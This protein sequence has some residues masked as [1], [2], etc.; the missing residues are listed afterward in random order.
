MAVGKTLIGLCTKH[1]PII[2]FLLLSASCGHNQKV[3]S[4]KVT[5]IWK[6]DRAV[7]ISILQPFPSITEQDSVR[8][9]LS[10]R[11][12]DSIM[13]PAI[14]GEYKIKGDE[15]IF[16]PLIAFTHGL[17][18][19]MFLKNKRIAEIKIPEIDSA[20]APA[21]LA[22]YPTQDTLPYNL[23]KVYLHF[24]KPMREGQSLKYITVLKNNKDTV[25]DVF[26]ELQPEL[27]NAEGTT[28]TLWLDPGRIKRDLQPNKLLGVPLQQ[29]EHYVLLFSD[30]W[31]DIHGARLTKA[32]SKN[33]IVT[34]RDGLSP[35]P[36]KWKIHT[37]QA[38]TV[39]P[40][41]IDFTEPLDKMLINDALN[42]VDEKGAVITGRLQTTDEER[43][44]LFKP[45]EPWIAGRYFIEI[46]T[47]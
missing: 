24:S 41:E 17:H 29:G 45:N 33:F 31:K 2:F 34:I 44:C 23:L 39:D 26:L 19:E 46:E 25:P 38:G 9:F 28:L 6:D 15:I 16:E 32:Y 13:Q 11:L 5:I 18:Y 37:P 27:W 12:T 43:K 22:V 36:Y 7:A 14:L 42:I 35:N 30:Q 4:S 47:R 3:S 1:N 20:E 40:M 21:L 8:K 10:V